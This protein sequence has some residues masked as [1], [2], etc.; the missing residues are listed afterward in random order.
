MVT[1]DAQLARDIKAA[2][3]KLNQL[4]YAAAERGHVVQV[5]ARPLEIV[6][7]RFAC[8]TLDVTVSKPL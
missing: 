2:V 4:I 8:P 6:G 7:F 5:D 3:S 1:E